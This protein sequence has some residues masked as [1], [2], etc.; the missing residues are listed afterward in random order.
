[1]SEHKNDF[2]LG[3]QAQIKDLARNIVPEEQKSVLH[4]KFLVIK[5][6]KLSFLTVLMIL[7]I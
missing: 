1:M 5:I 7:R 2:S 3:E 6:M 4:I